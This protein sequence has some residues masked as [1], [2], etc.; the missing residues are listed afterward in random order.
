MEEKLCSGHTLWICVC[1]RGH[2]VGPNKGRMMYF[3]PR[4]E[5]WKSNIV[6]R[7]VEATALRPISLCR[8]RLELQLVSARPG[9][10]MWVKSSPLRSHIEIVLGHFLCVCV[11]LKLK[12]RTQALNM[13][14]SP[15][16]WGAGAAI[17]VLEY[18]TRRFQ[19]SK[20]KPDCFNQI[21][22]VY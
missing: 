15:H 8:W 14:E 4:E 19:N 11:C 21:K 1:L 5:P 20:C 3:L 16:I 12:S 22:L 13:F 17:A 10:V 7:T 9:G 6:Q 2:T 18:S